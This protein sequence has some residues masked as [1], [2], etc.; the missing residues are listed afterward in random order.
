MHT[1]DKHTV[2][3][4]CSLLNVLQVSFDVGEIRVGRVLKYPTLGESRFG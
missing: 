1:T 3:A 4:S 2:K